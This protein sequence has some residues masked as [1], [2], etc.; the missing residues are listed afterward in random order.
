M[1]N[2]RSKSLFRGP[3]VKHF[4]LVHRSVR[5]P[6][7]NDPES[8]DRVLAEVQ[9]GSSG[10]VKVSSVSTVDVVRAKAIHTVRRESQK[11][12]LK[13]Y[14]ETMHSLVSGLMRAKLLRMASCTMTASMTICNIYEKSATTTSM[15]HLDFS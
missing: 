7:S 9:R 5:D 1:A 3:N 2:N 13:I 14:L 8:S 6:L 11:L 15:V 4:A 12:I 10:K